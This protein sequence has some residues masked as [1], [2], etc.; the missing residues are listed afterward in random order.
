MDPE[1]LNLGALNHTVIEGL[2]GAQN[3]RCE[4]LPPCCDSIMQ[5]LEA[6]RNLGIR[7]GPKPQNLGQDCTKQC[8]F[9]VHTPWSQRT[10]AAQVPDR[11]A[12]DALSCGVTR[13]LLPK[14][15][16]EPPERAFTT[17]ITFPLEDQQVHIIS[18]FFLFFLF[19]NT[20]LPPPIHSWQKRNTVWAF[21]FTNH[22]TPFL[23]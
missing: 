22:G 7:K 2:R 20:S 10:P 12:G 1:L 8:R 15:P 16:N 6:E 4:L 3:R 21:A 11:W 23:S 9:M 5:H 13:G 19:F 18:W 17:R 14:E